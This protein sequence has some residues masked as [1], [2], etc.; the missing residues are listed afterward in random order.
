VIHWEW[1]ESGKEKS[2]D[3]LLDPDQQRRLGLALVHL[4]A[5][6]LPILLL[7]VVGGSWIWLGFILAAY[8]LLR[9]IRAISKLQ[10]E[11]SGRPP[12]NS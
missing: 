11:T 4:V 10:A 3:A 12:P 7:A 2:W 6:P 9:G 1:K 5:V 8:P